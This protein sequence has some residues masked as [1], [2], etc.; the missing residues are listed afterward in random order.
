MTGIN[1]EGNESPTVTRVL[2]DRET[3]HPAEAVSHDLA[4]TA[5]TWQASISPDKPYDEQTNDAQTG[6]NS[7]TSPPAPAAAA[8]A[9]MSPQTRARDMAGY[10]AMARGKWRAAAAAWCLSGETS[11]TG[12]F[13]E[14]RLAMARA[15]TPATKKKDRCSKRKPRPFLR[16]RYC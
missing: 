1:S 2:H 6:G 9:R 16:W 3:N 14:T 5:M 11:Q 4:N 10:P 13:F 12:V 7:R 8:A 15:M